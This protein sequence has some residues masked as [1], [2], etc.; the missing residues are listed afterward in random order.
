LLQHYL[1]GIVVPD[2][3]VMPKAIREKLKVSGTYEELCKNPVSIG[4]WTYVQERL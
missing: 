3:D 2:A 4:F 1:V